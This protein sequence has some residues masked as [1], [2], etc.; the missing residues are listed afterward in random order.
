M[1]CSDWQNSEKE[2]LGNGKWRCCRIGSPRE[3]W[4]KES[5]CNGHPLNVKTNL[6]GQ[7]VIMG[8]SLLGVAIN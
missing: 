3:R 1:E 8:S 4:K 6:C 5:S 7:P 2:L